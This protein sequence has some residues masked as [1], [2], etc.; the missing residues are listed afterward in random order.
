M[1]NKGS[2][3]RIRLG[4]VLLVVIL[5]TL[6][7]I[8][9]SGFWK[10]QPAPDELRI[11][12]PT[13]PT[14][15][16]IAIA[17]E[18]GFFARNGIDAKISKYSSGKLAVEA[19]SREEIDMAT[20]NQTPLVF[21]YLNNAKYKIIATV[22][23]SDDILRILARSDRGILSPKDLIGKKVAMQER[24]ASEF[25][26]NLFLMRYQ[27]SR[28]KVIHVHYAPDR[29]PEAISNGEVDA[30]V[31]REPFISEA[32]R[33]LEDKA[34]IFSEPS[35][36]TINE[37]LVL[38]GSI[39]EKDLG[40]ASRILKS[41]IEAEEFAISNPDKAIKISSKLLNIPER[42][43]ADLWPGMHL[44]ISLDQE[45]VYALNE[46]SQWAARILKKSPPSRKEIFNFIVEDGLKA[47]DPNRVALIR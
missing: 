13:Q 17:Y 7:F 2:S 34:V 16:L 6:I 21:D 3:Q 9:A 19:L 10:E 38:P 27:I 37:V 15:A 4:V 31:I 24:S 36:Y 5:A 43:L 22:A 41:L 30:I 47:L 42:D 40:L 18:K 11:G 46:E 14:S 23:T 39:L 35:L 28:E 33:L 29:M 45:L 32:K 25:F 1:E 12:L 20:A 44:R 8:L 26:L